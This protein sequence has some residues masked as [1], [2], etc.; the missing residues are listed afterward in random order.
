MAWNPFGPGSKGPKKKIGA[1]IDPKMNWLQ[2]GGGGD[3]GGDWQQGST[4][5]NPNDPYGDA[6]SSTNV[7]GPWT[8]GA[9]TSGYGQT[10]VMGGPQNPA[11][12]KTT[13]PAACPDGQTR[14]AS[15][16]CVPVNGGGGNM[17]TDYGP[18]VDPWMRQFRGPATPE[19]TK[20]GYQGGGRG[21]VSAQPRMSFDPFTFQAFQADPMAAQDYAGFQ[22]TV[23][24]FAAQGFVAPTSAE[25]MQD[26]GYQFRLEE[27]QR[28]L[29][30]SAAAKGMLRTGNTWKDLQRYGQG[31]ATSE[32]DK[33]YGR[34]MGE[35]QQDYQRQLQENQLAYQR[36]LQ[37]YG[38]GIQAQQLG[39]QS[40]LGALQAN[41]GVQA[42]QFGQGSQAWQQNLAAR[43]AQYQQDVGR[44]QFEAQ[45]SEAGA[46]RDQQL[47]LAI[48]QQEE[49][50]Y[51]RQY[52]TAL[53][54]YTMDYAQSEENQRKLYDRKLKIAELGLQA[55]LGISD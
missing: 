16:N 52:E 31:M 44:R 53:K 40:R 23:D 33:V 47:A 6:V 7:V 49:R 38:T 8:A 42:Q 12:T 13:G 20:I 14:D 36:E 21:M 45:M 17:A 22:T 27:G 46:N 25:A 11:T 55:E 51:E 18:Y 1:G 30:Q 15:G 35:Y 43:Q 41:L 24:P 5:Y 29:E 10:G 9:E 32:Y 34:R 19:Y 2:Y 54:E 28:A 48:R 50:D 39:E 4:E 26:P 37:G 3:Y